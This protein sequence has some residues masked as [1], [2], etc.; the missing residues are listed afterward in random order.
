MGIKALCNYSTSPVGDG[1]I[2]RELNSGF[3]CSSHHISAGKTQ[4]MLF[5]AFFFLL[6]VFITLFP[7]S[8]SV[9]TMSSSHFFCITGM[10]T[11]LS[12]NTIMT[13]RN[14]WEN[15]SISS[16][17]GNLHFIKWQNYDSFETIMFMLYTMSFVNMQ[18]IH[19]CSLVK[20][21]DQNCLTNENKIQKNETESM[22]FYGNNFTNKNVKSTFL[23]GR[24]WCI[25]I[26]D[27][28]IMQVIM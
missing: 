4:H 5:L 16:I 13:M 21:L 26:L 25:N 28:Q 18:D 1:G 27:G 3:P 8:C 14:G 11:F 2:L 24:C 7:C 20:L 19:T 23:A 6:P 22:C 9:S 17:F 10:L 12:N 15:R